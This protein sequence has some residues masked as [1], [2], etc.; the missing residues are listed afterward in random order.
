MKA[1]KMKLPKLQNFYMAGQWLVP[2]GGLP[3]SAQTGKWAVQLICKKR[4]QQFISNK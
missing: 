4:K 2:G 1:L 3:P